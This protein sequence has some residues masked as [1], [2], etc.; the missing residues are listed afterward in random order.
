MKQI[1][2]YFQNPLF[3]KAKKLMDIKAKIDKDLPKHLTLQ[4]SLSQDIQNNPV[5]LVSN[6]VWLLQL[7]D[8]E[9]IFKSNIRVEFDKHCVLL[10]KVKPGIGCL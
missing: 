4:Y 7:K 1:Q 2:D 9:H 8:F 3:I 5:V 10:W 6:A